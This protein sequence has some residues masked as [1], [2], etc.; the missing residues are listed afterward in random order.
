MPLTP[1]DLDE[2]LAVGLEANPWSWRRPFRAR[3]VRLPASAIAIRGRTWYAIL[4]DPGSWGYTPRQVRQMRKE[5]RHVLQAYVQS[6]E[7][8]ILHQVADQ[9]R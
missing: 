8:A 3:Y 7:N 2:M 4:D 6:L 9:I 5:L 1:V